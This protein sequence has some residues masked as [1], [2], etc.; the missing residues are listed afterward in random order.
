MSGHVG[1]LVVA[2]DAAGPGTIHRGP[3][4]DPRVVAL[5]GETLVEL[6][7]RAVAR[8]PQRTALVMRRGMFDER[9]S[10]ADLGERTARVAARLAS[11]GVQPGDRVV[12]WGPAD[13]WLATAFFAVWQR[14]AIVVPLDLRM[15]EDVALRIAQR[16]RPRLVLAGEVQAAGPATA[17]G[18][19][20]VRLAA[21][22]L[23]AE[24]GEGP[25]ADEAVV[26]PSM[27]AEIVFTSGTTSD[28]KGVYLTHGQVIHN[29]RVIAQTGMG[30]QPERGLA[31]I[32]LSHMYGQIV[33][34][35][36][37]LVSGSTLVFLETLGAKS[38]GMALRHERI[39]AITA[40]PQLAQLVLD[41]F[42]SEA[43]RRGQ[44]E[45]MLRAR[46]VARHLP[47]RLR[48]LLFRRLHTAIGGRLSIITSGSAAMPEALQEAWESMGVLI[49]QGY[50]GTEC[51]AI[52]GHTRRDR[53][54]GTAGK[55]L[56]GL[57][58]Q[59][60][61]DGE[62]LV[63]GPSVMSGYW[64]AP[65][66]TTEVLT[67][68]GWLHTGDAVRIDEHGEVIVLGRTRYRIALPNGLKVYPD[69][70]ELALRAT[71]RIR[72]AVAIEEPPGRIA[73]VLLPADAEDTDATL[74]AAVKSAN[75]T[76]A[77][78]Q[79]VRGWRR[80]PEPDLPRTH[81]LKVK[82][83]PVA[84]WYRAASIGEQSSAG[85]GV[86]APL[87]HSPAAQDPLVEL[88]RL[89]AEVSTVP[90][91]EARVVNAE[92]VLEELALDSL[93][94][95]SLALRID[96]VLGVPLP[97]EDIAAA[98]T[99]ADL[100]RRIEA[101]RGREEAAPAA[102]WALTRPARIVRELLDRTLTSW[103]LSVVARPRVEGLENV[104]GL[105]GPV[106]VCPNHASH[107]D[108]PCVRQAL[109]ADLRRHTAVAAAADYFFTHPI[110]GP[111]VALA[112]AAFP[113]GRT[114]DVRAS[115]ERVSDLLS[116]GWSVMLFPEGTRSLD[117]R[118]GHMREGIGLLATATSV[119]V[120]PTWI[121]GT[122]DILP[123]GGTLPR[124]KRGA[125]VV[126]RFG[127]PL[128][129]DRSTPPAEAAWLI[130]GAIASLAELAP[131]HRTEA[132]PS[133]EA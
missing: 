72:D 63:R 80:W 123:K 116:T 39:T 1:V 93:A 18:V 66:A 15:R 89:V 35:F 25:P 53:R 95:L 98:S 124:R 103:L 64:E 73:A 9:W 71:G 26:D 82:R 126:V 84:D 74:A 41:T 31:I 42:E 69:D 104:A 102:A 49:V 130:G 2:G 62:L 57:E 77:D 5:T 110:L 133:K 90:G 79:R 30:P 48:R 85:T 121:E 3:P 7:E 24:P 122:H 97:D 83:D 37:G 67:A 105:A 4:L 13:P 59:V 19:P 127:A 129:F 32:P 51:A 119:P 76:L 99:V 52:T 75:S 21:D 108:A 114:T 117:G 88:C 12:T 22:S 56:A 132:E 91:Q 46:R 23:M 27:G 20:V 112:M 28:P 40:V 45:R 16:T 115:M 107:L 86:G 33:P 87:T 113:F 109:P 17:L 60:A 106:L 8:T 47:M 128:R 6:L 38:I 111:L 43:A 55:P 54:P 50:G 29:A 70:V 68:D 120:L 58:V 10:Y 131:G 14:G 100:A 92:T 34:L 11:L 101:Q 78:H 96:E 61:P 118:L 65:E 44:L 94:R 125:G 36:T 81:T